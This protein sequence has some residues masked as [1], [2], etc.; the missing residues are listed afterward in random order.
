ML[1]VAPEISSWD[2]ADGAFALENDDDDMG[3]KPIASNPETQDSNDVRDSKMLPI[4]EVNKSDD[5]TIR[6]DSGGYDED[7]Q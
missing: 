3:P 7:E 4:I 1:V 6:V 5:E 2:I